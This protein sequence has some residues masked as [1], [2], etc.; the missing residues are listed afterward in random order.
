MGL[1]P[2]ALKTNTLQLGHQGCFFPEILGVTDDTSSRSSDGNSSLLDEGDSASQV[3]QASVELVGYG[4]VIW[5][6]SLS[7][8]V[9]DGAGL[10]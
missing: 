9:V 4:R 7:E 6:D 5:P 8:W 2:P 1:E 3:P 10:Q